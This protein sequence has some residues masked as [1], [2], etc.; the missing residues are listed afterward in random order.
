MSFLSYG[1]EIAALPALNDS[2]LSV[3]AV[4]SGLYQTT[5]VDC[6]DENNI[7]VLEKDGHV[8]HIGNDQLMGKSALDLMVDS[9]NERGLLGIA[10]VNKNMVKEDGKTPDNNENIFNSHLNDREVS[11]YYTKFIKDKEEEQLRNK[12]YKIIG[13]DIH[14]ILQP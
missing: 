14:Y 10:I 7:L 5:N 12:I 3:E 11:L 9:I 8:R 13:M 4:A 6:I 2:F 1:K